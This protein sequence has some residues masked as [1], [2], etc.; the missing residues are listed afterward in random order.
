MRAAA[1]PPTTSPLLYLQPTHVRT[2]AMNKTGSTLS[3]RKHTST[4]CALCMIHLD[5][6]SMPCDDDDITVHCPTSCCMC[7]SLTHVM[8]FQPFAFTPGAHQ[9]SG[10]TQMFDIAA[11][12]VTKLWR[13][14]DNWT[15]NVGMVC[16]SMLCKGKDLHLSWCSSDCCRYLHPWSEGVPAQDVTLLVNNQSVVSANLCHKLVTLVDARKSVGPTKRPLG[17]NSVGG[18]V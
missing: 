17:C 14:S 16:K 13:T 10:T 3:K 12:H 4:L 8:T 7:C 15:S 18:I 2:N 1:Y 6:Y 11:S 9:P 5:G